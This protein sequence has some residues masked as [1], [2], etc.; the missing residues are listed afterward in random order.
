VR[1]I[2]GKSPGGWKRPFDDPILH[3]R[4]RQLVTLQDAG[5]YVTK[6]PKAEHDTAEWQAAMESLL[7]VVEPGGPTTFAR[8]GVIRDTEARRVEHKMQKGEVP[9]T[10]ASRLAIRL[11]NTRTDATGDFNRTIVYPRAGFSVP[12]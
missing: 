9:K 10:I 5:H 1:N 11:S 8:L 7:L 6:L 12:C 3:P 2:R 4:G